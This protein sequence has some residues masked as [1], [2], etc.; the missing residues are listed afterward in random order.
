MKTSI[1][2]I[3]LILALIAVVVPANVV[4]QAPAQARSPALERPPADHWSTRIAAP[5]YG[6][7]FTSVEVEYGEDD[8]TEVY[9]MP[10]IDLRHFN[11]INVTESGHFYFGYEVGVA[12][13]FLVG[14]GSTMD[15]VGEEY[16]LNSAM[17]ATLLLM[18]KHG[19]HRDIGSPDKGLGFGV[20]L[21]LGIMGGAGDIEI[22]NTDGDTFSHTTEII[23]PVFEAA[24][25]FSIRTDRDLRLVCR[26]GLM[27]GAPLIETDDGDTGVDYFSAASAPVRVS[28][29]FGFVRDYGWEY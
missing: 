5:G 1:L 18:G 3:T 23:G 29:R 11:G 9:L 2:H 26:L 8:E 17:V 14:S 28:L 27:A 22:E 10:G 13:N 20:E 15:I 6:F 12:A 16:E 21:G 4:A 25:E 7:S 19:Y 24:G